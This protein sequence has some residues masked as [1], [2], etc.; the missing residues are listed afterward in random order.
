MI[1]HGAGLLRAFAGAAVPSVSVVLRKAYGG[2]VITMNSRALGADLVLGWPD[3]EI[4]VVGPSR[5]SA[6]SIA[7]TSA[8]RGSGAG[9]RGWPT[10]TPLEHSTRR[11]LPRAASWT[12]S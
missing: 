12:R 6:W 11:S 1:R 8:R 4:G 10:C 9:A 2:G 7:G 5:P 3:A